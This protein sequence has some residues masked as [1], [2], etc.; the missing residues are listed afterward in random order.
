MEGCG[1]DVAGHIPY[2]LLAVLY[3]GW[4]AG[5]LATTTTPNAFDD[6]GC[7]CYDLG[8]CAAVDALVQTLALR[9]FK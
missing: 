7:W 9:G 3:V 8:Y 5:A 6:A 2:C 1:C 4:S